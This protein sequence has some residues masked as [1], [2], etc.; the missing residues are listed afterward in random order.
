MA[1]VL[2]NVAN[3]MI[4]PAQELSTFVELAEIEGCSP[5]LL[6]KLGKY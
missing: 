4:L 2:P 3:C 6:Q 1:K 5:V